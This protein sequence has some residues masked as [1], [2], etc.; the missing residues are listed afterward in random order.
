MRSVADL[1]RNDVHWPAQCCWLQTSVCWS[2]PIQG[3]EKDVDEALRQERN[4]LRW[5]EPQVTVQP[6]H[7]DHSDH[8]LRTASYN[9]SIKTQ[10]TCGRSMVL[11]W[12]TWFKYCNGQ[13]LCP[14]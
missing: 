12:S 14:R 13:N 11:R 7:S 6:L 10:V 5:P 4:L 3:R 9:S 1:K 8:S 2:T